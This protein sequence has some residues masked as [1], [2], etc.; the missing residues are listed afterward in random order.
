MKMEYIAGLVASAGLA[1]RPA[2]LGKLLHQIYKNLGIFPD[3]SSV[4]DVVGWLEY[5][6]S[7]K[8]FHRKQTGQS[9][10][11]LRKMASNQNC[12]ATFRTPCIVTI[13]C[14][15]IGLQEVAKYT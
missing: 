2:F 10:C 6:F 8:I 14:K 5:T 9:E 7:R 11:H 15:P 12:K 13:Y 1:Q 4:S 3:S